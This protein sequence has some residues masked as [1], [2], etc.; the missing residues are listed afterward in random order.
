MGVMKK[1][2]LKDIY[3]PIII[4]LM[5]LASGAL[6]A[7]VTKTLW[8]AITITNNAPVVFNS[9]TTINAS[10]TLTEGGMTQF[11]V[12]FNVTD[13]D[14]VND[15][16]TTK[17]GVNITFNGVKRSNNSGNC[18]IT[19]TSTLV[20]GYR[21]IVSFYY[22]DNASSFWEVN[23]SSGDYYS[24]VSNSSASLGSTSAAH[25]LSI[26]SLSAMQLGTPNLTAT[27]SMGVTSQELTIIINN[28]GNFDFSMINV[29]PFDLN[30]S[31]TD[32]FRL[33]GNFTVNATK[34]STGLGY[35][36]TN[37]TSYNFTE[38]NSVLATLP[39]GTSAADTMDNRTL[40]IYVTV[41]MNKGLSTGVPY[42]A[43]APWQI[44]TT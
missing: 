28:T 40:Y 11:T 18:E 23:L 10:I 26:G 22:Y 33:G 31:T 29:T 14:G 7:Q 3:I 44:I 39:H 34:S 42:N 15:I 8:V 6:A 24:V 27:Y 37:G 4:F 21:C 30:A 16:N 43:S 2:R 5:V 32:W 12:N 36:I 41:P 20:R 38:I 17:T 13:P 25:N 9:S 19:S 35:N 1:G